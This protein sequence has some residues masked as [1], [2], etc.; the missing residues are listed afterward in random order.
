MK[1]G[2]TEWWRRQG[3]CTYVFEGFISSTRRSKGCLVGVAAETVDELY[4]W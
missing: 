2:G 1:E 4:F 3:E